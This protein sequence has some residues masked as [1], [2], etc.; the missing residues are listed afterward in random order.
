[1]RVAR[2]TLT[3]LS[4]IGVRDF[5]SGFQHVEHGA[6]SSIVTALAVL[7]PWMPAVFDHVRR[8]RLRSIRVYVAKAAIAAKHI[9]YAL[10][11]RAVLAVPVRLT[12]AEAYD[13]APGCITEGLTG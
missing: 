10:F 4:D 11:D 8:D 13:C 6:G 5:R 9:R 7:P 3:P 2:E 1:V 12:R